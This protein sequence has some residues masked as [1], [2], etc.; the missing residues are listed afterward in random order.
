[1]SR[2]SSQ[3]RGANPNSVAMLLVLLGGPVA[4]IFHATA[5]I[6]IVGL[7]P[8]MVAFFVDRS[9]NKMAPLTIGSLNMCGVLPFLLAL[10]SKGHTMANAL[11]L[12]ASPLPWFSMYGA[13]A[14]GWGILYGVPPAV[15]NYQVARAEARRQE[16]RMRQSAL[17]TE[18]GVDVAGEDHDSL[19]SLP[20]PPD[21]PKENKHDGHGEGPHMDTAS[22]AGSDGAPPQ[23]TTA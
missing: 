18:W 15:A 4:L 22:D 6:L 7:I 12:L 11:S 8:T 19:A 23:E 1:M 21:P 17:V 20:P 13:A 14:A 5:I 10:W 16:L 9:P 3:K 2:R